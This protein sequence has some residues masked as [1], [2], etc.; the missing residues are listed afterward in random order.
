MASLEYFVEL[1]ATSLLYCTPYLYLCKD[2]E[3]AQLR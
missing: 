3:T 2:N 1:K